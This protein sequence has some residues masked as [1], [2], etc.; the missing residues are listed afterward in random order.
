[1][2]VLQLYAK[3]GDDGPELNRATR[4][5]NAW[6]MAKLV[7]NSLAQG[8]HVICVRS[9]LFF[10][11]LHYLSKGQTGDYN[12]LPTSLPMQLIIGHASLTDA[13]A[14]THP[15]PPSDPPR[16]NE[17]GAAASAVTLW[18]IT[19][20]SP[21]NS[22][23]Q[24]K[25]L[26]GIA[27]KWLGKRLDYILF[28]SPKPHG[29]PCMDVQETKV[30]FTEKVP[31]QNYSYSDHFGLEAVFTIKSAEQPGPSLSAV[32]TPPV[33]NRVISGLPPNRAASV[34][35]ERTAKGATEMSGEALLTALGALT[36]EYRSSQATTQTQLAYFY[37]AVAVLV[38]VLAGSPYLTLKS[39]VPPAAATL[40][41]LATWAGTTF[42]Y[43]GF[44]FGKWERNMLTNIIEE[45]E[46]LKDTVERRSLA[47]S[48]GDH[49]VL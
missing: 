13:W 7:R 16:R 4:I 37:I 18:G 33:M 38:L 36:H 9:T 26:E 30:V 17:I 43:I 14:A 8:R 49:F 29:G 34:I 45:M 12:S 25:P 15:Q 6:E 31:G 32:H 35:E 47:R 28:R 40:A 23:S 21:L 39:W 46:T 22:W 10:I 1:M 11:L 20:D 27:R 2:E 44:I 24:G 3:G 19:A 48:P 41:G 5:S 42:L